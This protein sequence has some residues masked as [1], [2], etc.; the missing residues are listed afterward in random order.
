MEFVQAEAFGADKT[1]KKPFRGSEL[2]NALETL[3]HHAGF[4]LHGGKKTDSIHP[5]FA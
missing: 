2:L 3:Q 1:L 5:E 4:Q